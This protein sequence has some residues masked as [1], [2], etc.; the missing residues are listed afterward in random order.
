RKIFSA[1]KKDS[2]AICF[3]ISSIA[4]AFSF[5]I[6]FFAFSTLNCSARSAFTLASDKMFSFNFNASRII[7]SLSFWALANNSSFPALRDSISRRACC[8]ALKALSID[9]SRSVNAFNIGFQA[10]R[11][12]TKATMPKTMIIQKIVPTFG[13]TNSISVVFNYSFINRK[14]QR[15]GN[16]GYDCFKIV[17][18]QTEQAHK[19]SQQRRKLLQ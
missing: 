19:Q 18:T 2:S 9:C 10:K 8:A 14:K 15:I 1:I 12:N 7:A 16:P 4:F 13:V 3:F 11:F 5:S 6:C 17:A